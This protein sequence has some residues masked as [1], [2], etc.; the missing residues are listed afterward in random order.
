MDRSRKLRKL[1]DI[2]ACQWGIVASAQAAELG[3]TRLD[4]SRFADNGHLVR[5]AHGVYRDAG[6]LKVNL[7]S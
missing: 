1:S 4:L 3:V 6:A 2:T 5:L 7:M